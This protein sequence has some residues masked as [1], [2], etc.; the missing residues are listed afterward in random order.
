MVDSV[1]LSQVLKEKREFWPK[2]FSRCPY[3]KK[4]SPGY[5]FV[6]GYRRFGIY[7]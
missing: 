7:N 2:K 1:G 4:V 3:L 5:I 6:S